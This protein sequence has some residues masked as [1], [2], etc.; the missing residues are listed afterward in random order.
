M[1]EFLRKM[2]KFLH[3]MIEFLRKKQT[4]SLTFLLNKIIIL[5]NQINGQL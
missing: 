4:F 5:D 1:I 3:K 2:I